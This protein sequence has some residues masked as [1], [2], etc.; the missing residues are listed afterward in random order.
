[1]DRFKAI[2][3]NVSFIT[4]WLF[5]LLFFSNPLK[6]KAQDTI[7]ISPEYIIKMD[8]IETFDTILVIDTLIKP[9]QIIKIDTIRTSQAIEANDIEQ[10]TKYAT[11]GKINGNIGFTINQLAITHWAAGGESNASGKVL[12]DF[13]YTIDKKK[14]SYVTSGI[15]AYGISGYAKSKRVEK[16]EDRFEMSM[17][18]SN[19]NQK[20]LTFTSIATLKTQFTNG[21][22]Y[23]NDSVPISSFFA[24]AYLTLSVGYTY[25][26]SKNLSLFFSPVA[27]KMTFVL[28]QSLADQGAFGVEAGYWNVIAGDSIW[29]PGKNF[30]GELGIN[31]LV[32][33]ARDFAPNISLF[34]T[35]NCYNNYLDPNKSNRWNIDVDWETGLKMTISKRISTIINIH[36]IYDDNIKFAVTEFEDGV[37]V[38]K[39]RPILQFKE[40][41]GITFLYKFAN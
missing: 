33:Y 7:I 38:V 29:V 34:S 28:R 24:P 5:G 11:A 27:G 25:T 6:V 4:V 30:L 15:F 22:S 10:S 21:Y 19:N 9:R 39:H 1:M 20:H 32:K 12:A 26:I 3:N 31:I 40:S 17:T 18:M 14:F 36:F 37:E 2:L 41:L 16:T 35:L 13:K 8:T 23:P